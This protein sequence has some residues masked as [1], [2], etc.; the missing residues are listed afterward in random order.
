M[1]KITSMEDISLSQI[2]AF[3]S[4]A[5]NC[6]MTKGASEL[7][8]TQ[9]AIS[10]RISSL[11]QNLGLILFIRSKNGLQLTPAGKQLY[12]DLLR[13]YN[14]MEAAF[15]SAHKLQTGKRQCLTV[16]VDSFFDWELLYQMVER[17][18]KRYESVDF[19]LADV[20]SYERVDQILNWKEMDITITVEDYVLNSP[21]ISYR[22]FVSWQLYALVNKKNPLAEKDEISMEELCHEPVLIPVGQEQKLYYHIVERLY[23]K[24]GKKP[25][26]TSMSGNSDAYYIMN[27]VLNKGIA[28]AS[29]GF[30]HKYNEKLSMY[31]REHIKPI[32]ISGATMDLCFAW[33]TENANPC[34]RT[35]LNVMDE[36]LDEGDNWR[37]L[38]EGYNGR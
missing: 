7:C 9:S 23:Q 27:V 13:I 34:I 21:T 6:S 29:P 35:F 20:A 22:K 2:S 16:G 10:Q 3:L 1:R 15:I 17:F 4:V 28:I 25:V 24:Y 31:A 33:L 14:Q 19:E 26:V 37:I 18:E 32:K 12:S 30:W 8:L 36:V 38:D 5:K 11:E